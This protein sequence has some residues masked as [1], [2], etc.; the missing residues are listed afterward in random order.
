MINITDILKT[1]GITELSEMQQRAINT[2]KK[3]RNA[4]LLSPTGSGKTL[5]FLIPLVEEINTTSD[6]V[7]AIILSPSRELAIQTER[8]LK[9]MKTDVRS[10]CLY[11]GRPT[12]D[13]HRTLKS[14]M[15][16]IVIATPGRLNDH[17]TKENLQAYGVC[18]LVIDEFDKCLEY[19]FQNEMSDVIHKLPGLQKRI[20]ISATDSD[21]IPTFVGTDSKNI[22]KLNYL[23][24]GNDV[25]AGISHYVVHAPDVDKLETLVLLLCTLKGLSTVVFVNYRESVERIGL[26]LKK[27]GFFCELFHGGM[28]QEDRERAL[29]KFRNGSSNVLVSTDL[30]ARGLDIPEL[31]NVVHYH[32]PQNGDGYIHRSGRTGR[33]EASGKSFLIVNSK[34]T[35]PEYENI[36]FQEFETDTILTPPVPPEWITLYIGRGKKEK[37]SKMDI[38]G[39]LCKKGKANSKDIGSIDIKDHHSY[40]AV[41]RQKIN[42]ILI[43]VKGEKIKGLKTIVEQMK[44]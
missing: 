32:L 27:K 9:Q 44:K 37:L 35:V 4:V 29:G 28:E 13:E 36:E 2:F 19:G 34:E 31:E 8:V 41:K 38:L 6:F 14:L 15:P 24:Q 11:G 20:L 39:F 7:Q 1:L 12:M 18:T 3:E 33:W 43:N 22:V 30:S 40:A 5:A 10:I 26:E 17:L 21:D 25:P 23:T 16:H 42:Q